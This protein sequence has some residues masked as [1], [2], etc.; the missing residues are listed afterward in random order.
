MDLVD[1]QQIPWLHIDQKT[2]DVPGTLQCGSTGDA[3]GHPQFLGQHQ[4]HGGLSETR[5]A[6][7]QY[8]VQGLT[9]TDGRLDGDAQHLFQ[10]VLADVVVQAL[11]P[12]SI[13]GTP[14]RF[15]RRRLRIEHRLT[16]GGR[17]AGVGRDDRHVGRVPRPG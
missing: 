10:L 14:G 6:I 15:F 16:A 11:G 7:K 4:G 1:E 8:M 17:G 5:R 2:H 9:T 3:A 12:Q 13:V